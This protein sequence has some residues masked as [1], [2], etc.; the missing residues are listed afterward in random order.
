[1]EF[2]YFLSSHMKNPI[3]IFHKLQLQNNYIPWVILSTPLNLLFTPTILNFLLLFYPVVN[4]LVHSSFIF[5]FVSL[6]FFILSSLPSPL[7]TKGLLSSPFPP[8][9]S[10]SHPPSLKPT[11][12][13]LFFLFF[14]FSL[15]SSP[16]H[17]WHGNY[18]IDLCR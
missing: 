12:S 15:F 8:S 5:L 2:I 14:F 1:M 18:I 3:Y 10:S 6:H 11:N 7:H 16:P 17:G 4:C 13:L 9:S